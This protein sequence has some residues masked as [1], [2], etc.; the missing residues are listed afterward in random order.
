[1][2]KRTY[3]GIERLPDGRKRI[4]LAPVDPRTGRRK[5]IDRVVEATMDEATR[6]RQQWMDEVRTVDRR[7]QEVPRFGDYAA[8]WMKSRAREVKASTAIGYAEVLDA[9]VLPTFGEWYL[10]KI[11]DQD[12]RRWRDELTRRLAAG[13]VNGAVRLFKMVM[14]AAVAEHDLGRNPCALV[15][16]LPVKGYDEEEPNLLT[17]SE[18]AAVLEAMRRRYFQSYALCLTLALT[19]VRKGEATALRWEDL[20]EAKGVIKVVRAQWRGIVST[21]KT[22]K[23]RSVP[24]VP[25]LAAVLR[26]HRARLVTRQAKG[27]EAGWVFPGRNGGLIKQNALRTALATALL[28]AGISRRLTVHGLRRSF[29]NLSRQVAGEIVTR[30]ITGHVTQEMTEHYSHVGRDEKLAAGSAVARLVLPSAPVG[31]EGESGDRCGDRLLPPSPL[32]N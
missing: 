9:R 19:G 14:E 28:Q 2:P 11:R 15:R 17:A 20:D 10:D 26:E 12:V 23:P 5:E 4:R 8:S 27:L 18:L 24:L 21:T 6:L 13:S 16:A 31:P 7:S 32:P 29:N 25:E 22:K 1:M 3:P 30:S